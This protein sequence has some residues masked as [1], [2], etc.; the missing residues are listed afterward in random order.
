MYAGVPSTAP[1]CVSSDRPA[2]TDRDVAPARLGEARQAEV[3]DQHAA[4]AR[5]QDVLGLDVAVDDAQLVRRGQSAPDLQ[6]EIEDP[7]PVGPRRRLRDPARHRPAVDQLHHDVEL[8]IDA[9][10]VVDGEHV[11]VRQRRE[12]LRLAQEARRGACSADAAV[13]SSRSRLTATLRCSL[14][15][16]AV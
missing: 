10:D 16:N 13:A 2:P 5:D 15:S 4:V 14:V 6:V 7:A 1:V 8:G 12:Q 11:R 3:A 9:A